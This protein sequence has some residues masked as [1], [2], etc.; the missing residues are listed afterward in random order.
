[1]LGDLA[2]A[3]ARWLPL[4]PTRALAWGSLV[5]QPLGAVTASPKHFAGPLASSWGALPPPSPDLDLW[6]SGVPAHSAMAKGLTPWPPPLPLPS[7]SEF[8]I[9]RA[10]VSG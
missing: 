1:M 3:L 9:S 4:G 6:G 10:C 2:N 7:L 8:S 5:P